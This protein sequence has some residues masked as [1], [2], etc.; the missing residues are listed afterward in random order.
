MDDHLQLLFVMTED[1]FDATKD[2]MPVATGGRTDSRRIPRLRRLEATRRPQ[3]PAHR[4]I[5]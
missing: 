2:N 3:P 4:D 5:P 1:L